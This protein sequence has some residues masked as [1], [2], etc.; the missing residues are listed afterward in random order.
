MAGFALA[1]SI[2]LELGLRMTPSYDPFGW[3]L[4]GRQTLHLA[5]DPSGAPSWKPL[6]W[7][8]T[9]PLALGGGAAPTLWLIVACA[10]GL[11]TFWLACRLASRLAGPVAGA[12]AVGAILLCRDWSASMLTGNIEPATAALVLGAMESLILGRQRLTLVLLW[13]AA[14]A[15]PECALLLAAY[16]LWLWR[17]DHGAHMLEVATMLALPVLW[18]LPPAIAGVGFG[19]HDPVFHQ[20]DATANPLVILYRAGTLYVWPVAM[21][22]LVG[23]V[24]AIRRPPEQRQIALLI[25]AGAA[26]W[27]FATAMM[28][29]AGFPGL[30]RFMLPAAAAGCVLAGAGVVWAVPQV[31][32]AVM[33]SRARPV[34]VAA[35]IVA[36]LLAAWY[37]HLR[38]RSEVKAARTEHVRSALERSLER[39]IIDAGGSRRLLRCG[40]PSA[41]LGYQS[42]LAWY[43]H[44]T[45]VGKVLYRPKRDVR[46]PDPIVLLATG[47]EV[48]FGAGG[49]L[50]GRAGPWRAVAIRPRASCAPLQRKG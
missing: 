37:A 19:S 3:L 8:L 45:S 32:A 14:L 31:C 15:R 10:A 34:G 28:S 33:A 49:L 7:L 42:V 4:W 50:L 38:V 18:F 23:L 43:L 25:A 44:T 35:L 11:L 16:S 20:S 29:A 24:L 30:Q 40:L 27:I 41:D 47:R 22:V 39:V 48:R 46:L 9:T 36:L 12:V 2:V 26:A 21:A 13:L 1:A 5:L 6:P 17:S